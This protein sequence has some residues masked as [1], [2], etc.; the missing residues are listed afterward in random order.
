MEWTVD[1]EEVLKKMHEEWDEYARSMRN[2]PGY[3]VFDRSSEITDMRFCYNQILNHIHEYRS[4]EVEWLLAYEKPLEALYAHW[5]IEHPVDFDAAFE[6]FF[7]GVEC[8][9]QKSGI[10]V[11]GMC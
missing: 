7:R 8:E 9:E 6:Y 11:S 2:L 4:D 5:V 10:E 3:E 1:H